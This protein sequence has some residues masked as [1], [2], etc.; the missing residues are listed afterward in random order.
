MLDDVRRGRRIIWTYA[1]I[2]LTVMALGL[3]LSFY[4]GRNWK[5]GLVRALTQTALIHSLWKGGRIAQWLHVAGFVMTATVMF[6][7]GA[8]RPSPVMWS[9][10]GALG[11]FSLWLGWLFGF[12]RSVRTFLAFQRGEV[13]VLADPDRSPEIP[14]VRSAAVET[15][16]AEDLAAPDSAWESGDDAVGRVACTGCGSEMKSFVVVCPDCGKRRAS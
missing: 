1:A 5:E 10:C 15:A 9:I 6:A 2:H 4:L 13:D 8:R 16:E 3:A 12:S 7:L 14:I 11:G